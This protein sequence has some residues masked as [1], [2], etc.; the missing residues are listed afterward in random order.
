MKKPDVEMT[1]GEHIEEL[2]RRVI[3]AL[4]GLVVTTVLCGVFY[5]HLLIALLRPY[6]VAT[7]TTDEPA[8]QPQPAPDTKPDAAATGTTTT[9]PAPATGAGETGKVTVGQPVTPRLTLGGPLTGYI[10]II[11]LCIICGIIL[12][13][14]WIMYQIWAFVGVGLH[15]H[16][17]RF[18][19]TYGPFSFFLFVLGAA[20]FYF[21]MLPVGLRALL[22]PTSDILRDGKL[23]IDPSF[24]LNDYFKFVALMT[25]ITGVVFQTPLVVMFLAR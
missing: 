23:L 5:K 10:T 15:P 1:F 4:L 20:T 16:E 24:F 6:A 25:L 12:A 18:V 19:R 9:P 14:P 21:V 22:S 11:L 3:Y 17:Q 13:S 7:R 8:P 2:R